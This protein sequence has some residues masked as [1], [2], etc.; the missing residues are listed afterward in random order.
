MARLCG[1][2]FS[3]LQRYNPKPPLSRFFGNFFLA[4][5]QYDA[6][7]PL[8]DRGGIVNFRGGISRDLPGI[9]SSL[10]SCVLDHLGRAVVLPVIFSSFGSPV[11]D[12]PLPPPKRRGLRGGARS[13]SR[14]RPLLPPRH[15]AFPERSP[16]NGLIPLL[17]EGCPEGAGWSEG[18]GV[19]PLLPLLTLFNHRNPLYHSEIQK[20]ATLYIKYV[21]YI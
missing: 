2:P 10:G 12:H 19:V 7:K 14:S 8:T 6:E 16:G 13:C 5:L 20:R 3:H 1:Q 17:Q 18:R 15:P 4:G 21:Y 11:L 9:S